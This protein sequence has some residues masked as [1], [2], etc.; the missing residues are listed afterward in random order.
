MDTL[1]ALPPA[2]AR[3]LFNGTDLDNWTTRAGTAA[4]WKVEGGVLHVVPGA[5][6]IMTREG[7]GDFFL[8]L[9]FRCPDMPEAKGQAKGNS[10]VFLQGRYEIQVLD[11]YGLSIPGMGDCGA[12]YN[13]FAPLVNAC[14]PALAW[15][16]YDAIFRTPRFDG[17]GQPS[18][19]ARLTLLHN[20]LVVHNN[21][22]FP[23]VTGGAVDERVDQPG[24]LLLQDHGNLVAYRNIWAMPL[25][26]EGSKTY[27]PR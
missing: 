24:P 18:E 7:L 20:G 25:P 10:G 11:S 19:G 26:P 27:E 3:R 9:E 12:I 16:T 23:G 13:Q 6:D 15:Q 8:H 2:G 1:Q 4:G 21:I 14:K 17:A 22:Q 5:G